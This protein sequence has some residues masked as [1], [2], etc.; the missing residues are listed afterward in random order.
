MQAT[1]IQSTLL[2]R[3]RLK[4]R[5]YLV[6]KAR[7]K[8]SQTIHM[9]CGQLSGFQCLL[10]TCRSGQASGTRC[11]HSIQSDEPRS[12]SLTTIISRTPGTRSVVVKTMIVECGRWTRAKLLLAKSRRSKHLAVLSLELQSVYFALRSLGHQAGESSPQSGRNRHDYKLCGRKA[13]PTL[14]C[15]PLHRFTAVAVRC[16]RSETGRAQI[17][18]LTDQDRPASTRSQEDRSVANMV[19]EP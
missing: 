4:K 1:C 9:K 11:T 8:K 18:D 2:V 10:H 13:R 19:C 6:C 15:L 14:A 12:K 17:P 3:R 5:N 16:C 7:L